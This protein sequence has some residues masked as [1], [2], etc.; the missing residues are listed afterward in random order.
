MS[1]NKESKSKQTNNEPEELKSM[2]TLE[3]KEGINNGKF[4]LDPAME[5]KDQKDGVG[6]AQYS[7]FPR[8]KYKRD[9]NDK[10][11]KADQGERC[12]VI[13]EEIHMEK[14]GLPRIDEKWRKTD[15][16]C[17]YFWLPLLDSD[18]GAV[19]LRTNFLTP[20]DEYNNQ[21]INVEGNKDY[22]VTLTNDKK[23]TPIKKLKYVNCVKLF[24]PNSNNEDNEAA[25]GS[26]DNTPYYRV[27]VRLAT[28]FDKNQPKDESKK[29][30]TQVVTCD[31]NGD[32]NET[33]EP[34][35][36]LEDMR[37]LF[38]WKCKV[39]FA[40][41]VNKFWAA[42]AIDSDLGA[43]KCSVTLKCIQMFIIE[44][45]EFNK[46]PTVLSSSVFGK[47]KQ[48]K[49]ENTNT[50]TKQ[51]KNQSDSSDDN[52]SNKKGSKDKQQT[53][54]K[55]KNNNKNKEENKEKSSDDSESD[56]NSDSE[57]SSDS[58][59]SEKKPKQDVKANKNKQK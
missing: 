4:Y 13:T 6:Q 26:D 43:R 23:R 20:L 27:K 16:D 39:R 55:N 45:P 32:P 37:K 53:N 40:I 22:A 34:I 56:S 19:D 31:A 7:L 24:D 17:L 18:P 29:I 36:C 28:V 57:S 30:K 46:T 52:D 41:E 21:K 48:I 14:G 8:F 42:K 9:K 38:V 1:K 49:N 12:I 33:P 5:G 44:R 54:D 35:S 50:N 15:N 2:P 47:K 59:D 25:H 58:S 51:I 11:A 3:F 10:N